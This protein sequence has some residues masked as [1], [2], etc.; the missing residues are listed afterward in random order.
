MSSIKRVG[1]LVVSFCALILITV[2]ANSAELLIHNFDDGTFGPFSPSGAPVTAFVVPDGEPDYVGDRVGLIDDPRGGFQ[3]VMQITT[4][5]ALA[6]LPALH[7][8]DTIEWEV[9]SATYTGDFL[10]N[11]V[12]F[13]THDGSQS[14][15]G[16]GFTVLD[17]SAR[18]MNATT[19]DQTYSHNYKT[20]NG[21]VFLD[22]IDPD[23]DGDIFE[24]GYTFF[25]IFIIQQVGDGQTSTV[26]YDNFRLTAVPEP[27]SA[28]LLL[29]GAA[30]AAFTGRRRG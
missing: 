1:L 19:A 7:A 8:H 3:V 18:F 13:Q 20:G 16:P 27:T 6:L 14:P 29:V 26:G 17:G 9:D 28:M 5:G 12:V 22:T 2:S 10:N 21:G 11:F 25:N 4:G 15:P 23:K 30:V 24:H